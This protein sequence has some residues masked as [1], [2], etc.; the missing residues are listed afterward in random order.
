MKHV[1]LGMIMAS[2]ITIGSSS[3]QAEIL[4]LKTMTEVQEKF[5]AIL[6]SY[7][8]DDVLGAVDIDMTLIQ[9]DHPA[10]YYPALKK[11][12]DVYVRIFEK[13]SKAQ[14]DMTNTFVVKM[15]PQRL[16]ES[17]APQIIKN[18]Q[19]K[20]KVI[21]FTATLTGKFSDLA[22]KAIF[23]RWDQLQQK[24]F[25]FTKSFEECRQCVAFTEIPQYAGSHPMFYHGILSSNGEG[26]SSKGET[27]IAFL[28]YIASKYPEKDGKAG[29]YPKVIVLVDDRMRNLREVQE[30]LKAYDP[31]IVFIGIEY[32]GAYSFAPQDISREDFK[33]F[34]ED[35]AEKAKGETIGG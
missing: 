27:L 15:F 18:L 10:T 30:K 16:V 7:P 1:T 23:L 35:I 3:V 2:L 33:K 34:W 13:L 12:R 11:H 29:Y 24:G 17:D 22:D 31:S 14:Q 5:D 21:A 20:I 26:Q 25:D 8:A 32:Q 6:E 9:P 28:K 19:Q 4:S